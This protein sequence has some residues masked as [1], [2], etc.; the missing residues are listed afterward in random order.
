MKKVFALYCLSLFL[1]ATLVSLKA[2]PVIAS[3]HDSDIAAHKF[4]VDSIIHGDLLNT[5]SETAF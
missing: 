2:G 1:I 3:G 5:L 4:M